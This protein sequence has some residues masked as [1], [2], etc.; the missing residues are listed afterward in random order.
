[1]TGAGAREGIE[2]DWEIVS[3][4][5]GQKAVIQIRRNSDDTLAAAIVVQSTDMAAPTIPLDEVTFQNGKLHFNGGSP[6]GVFEGTMKEDGL[7]IEGQFQ[8][9]GQT[10][11][12]ALRRVVAAVSEPSPASP[13]QL[14]GRTS[15]TSSIATALILVLALACV[16]AGIVFFLVKSSIR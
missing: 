16:V 12:L 11:A 2:G 10:M 15:G 9:Q 5:V 6:P 14:Q 7:T 3:S 4:Q 8:Q 1:V 13:E